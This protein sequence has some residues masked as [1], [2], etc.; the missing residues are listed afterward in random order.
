MSEAL[1]RAENLS[2]RFPSPAVR[3]A[4]SRDISKPLTK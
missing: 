4:G 2:K 1:V 3:L